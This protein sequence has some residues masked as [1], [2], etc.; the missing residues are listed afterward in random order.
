M[1]EFYLE[2]VGHACLL[3]TAGEEK[4]I[5]DP[6][7]TNPVMAN[8]WYHVPRYS[9]TI[10]ELPTL[11]YIYVSHE[12]ADHLDLP[13]LRS[14]TSDATIIIPAFGDEKMEQ[15]LHE[16]DLSQR[17]VALADG[18]EFTTRGGAT[19]VIYIA[20]TG[21]KD[22][23]LVVKYSDTCVYNNTDNWISPKKMAMIGN[24][25]DVD[26]AFQCYAGVG[27]FPSYMMWP[28]EYR[29]QRGDEKKI[30]LFN[31]MKATL[32]AL[33]PNTMVPFGASFGYLR[34][35]TLWLNKICATD[36]NECKDWL[37]SEGVQ[38]PVSLMDHGDFWSKSKGVYPGKIKHSLAIN[39]ETIEEYS[40]FYA[41]TIAKKTAEEAVDEKYLALNDE[42]FCDYL[43]AW[44]AS[45]THRF[46]DQP[47]SIQFNITGKHGAVWAVDF[48]SD[49]DI[50]S[51]IMPALPNLYLSFSDAEVFN[52]L[53]HRHYSLTDLYL[54]SRMQMNRYPYDT[55]HKE[56][57]DSF[58]WWS[59]GEQVEANR[60]K[61]DAV[62]SC[63]QK[64]LVQ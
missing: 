46:R 19:L 22:S 48:A 28:L 27:S 5:T 12:H 44:V 40:N 24:K 49:T 3:F 26:I 50:V 17:V 14:L 25:W 1:S 35:E 47:L 7:F 61:A 4:I 56:F 15:T 37:S 39:D 59:E 20:D 54:S 9:R 58:F 30:E 16:G 53:L 36:P 42:M 51:K 63:W 60:I 2:Y 6:W 23:S 55:Y 21:S 10:N 8:S 13:A 57:F 64:G 29:V 41:K 52:G 34:Q 43:N 32:L 45:E 38:I 18:E 11:D 33:Q 31:R 62:G